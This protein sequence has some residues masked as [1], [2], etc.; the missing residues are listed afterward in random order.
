MI[1]KISFL[2]IFILFTISLYSENNSI[3]GNIEK[4]DKYL[5][6][7]QYS[8]AI[9]AYNEVLNID[10]DNEIASIRMAELYTELRA[11]D[12]AEAFLVKIE[13]KGKNTETVYKYFGDLYY[14]RSNESKKSDE[15]LKYREKFYENYEKYLNNSGYHD[16]DAIYLLGNNYFIDRKFE[17]ANEVFINEKGNN[18]KNYFGAATTYRF[19]GYY[20]DAIKYYK[21]VLNINSDFYEAYLGL[22]ICYQLSGD[23]A[24][25]IYNFEKYLGYEEDENV[26]YIIAKIHYSNNNI[27]KA[28]QFTEK[29]LKLFPNFEPLK[30]I[31]IDIYTKI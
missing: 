12:A 17:T 29:G 8:R 5:A 7:K 13:K 19:L 21:K 20:P 27:Q 25:S 1:K 28:K 2:A 23:F 24:N 26:Y 30:E 22:G 31:M 14:K 3:T 16:S 4:G 6:K 15:K 18:I 10:E 11:Y 9:S